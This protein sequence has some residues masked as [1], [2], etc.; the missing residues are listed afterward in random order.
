MSTSNRPTLDD[1]AHL[2]GVSTAT[3]SRCLNFPDRVREPTKIRVDAAIAELGYTPHFGGM[4]LAS[5]RTNTIGAI[6]PT[7]E[8]AIFARG[9][10]FLQ[11]ELTQFGITL[12]VATSLYDP[13]QEAKQ[14][15]ALLGRGVDGLVLIGHERPE[16]SYQLLME[17]RIP[18]V[19]MWASTV[20]SPYC[21]VGFDNH[22]AAYDMATHVIQRGHRQIAMIGGTTKGNDRARERIK[23]VSDA[24]KQ[25]GLSLKPPFL[26]ETG[27]TIQ[28][29]MK[30]AQEF[31]ALDAPPTAII[32]GNDVQAAGALKAAH[33]AGLKVPSDLSV[34]GFDDIDLAEAVEPGLTTVH[35]PHRR[36][37]REAARLITQMAREQVQ[38]KS[39][40]IATYIVERSSLAPLS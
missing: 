28:E 10:Q 20:N 35:V 8:N 11:E 18:F 37:G 26:I 15:K 25:H 27:Y 6:I 29:G 5:N 17:R 13:E 39:I 14:I 21:H 36:M 34:V 33:K 38:G 24:M 1:V 30:A 16:S 40:R 9:L 22:R 12:L 3:V 7:M 32:C 19:L 23:G 4:A 2:A 31:L